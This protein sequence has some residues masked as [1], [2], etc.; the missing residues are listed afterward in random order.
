MSGQLVQAK[1]CLRGVRQRGSD[2]L[3]FTPVAPK[4]PLK[5]FN[6]TERSMHW[7]YEKKFERMLAF[8]NQ[9]LF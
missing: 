9:L 1:N 3:N 8:S 7:V 2:A 6:Q 5:F 4:N